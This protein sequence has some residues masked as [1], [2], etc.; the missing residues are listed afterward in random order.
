[1]LLASLA[2]VPAGARLALA[3]E[4]GADSITPLLPRV[5]V[6]FQGGTER[7]ILQT[8]AWVPL[9]QASDRVVYG[10]LRFSGDD[11][12]NREQNL[13]VGYRQMRGDVVYGG[14]VWADRRTTDR[15]STFYQTTLGAEAM[16]RNLEGRANVY[17]PLSKGKKYLTAPTGPAT[18]YLAGTGVYVNTAG[19]VI[20]E[21]QMG[22]DLEL[23]AR[24][25]FLENTVDSTRV[26]GGVY[27]FDSGKTENVSGWRTRLLLDVAPWLQVGGRYQHDGARG[28]QGFLEATFRFGGK[29]SFRSQGLRAR[30]DESAERD[31]DIV[32]S[33]AVVDSGIATPVVNA[34]TGT[35]QRILH[36]DNMA[37]PGGDGS[38]ERPFNTLAAAQAAIQ[39][40]DILYI[41]QGTQSTNGQNT[42]LTI[43][44]NG[45]SVIG[46]GSALVLDGA[47]LG[48]A[49]GLLPSSLVLIPAGAP[50]SITNTGGTGIAVN[51]D[52]ISIKGLIVDDPSGVGITATNRTGLTV[53]DVTVFSAGSQGLRADYTAPGD[54]SLNINRS[55]FHANNGSAI[56]VNNTAGTVSATIENNL[57]RQNTFS[58]VYTF[59]DGA[60]TRMT[61]TIRNNNSYANQRGFYSLTQNNA[62][63]TIAITGNSATTNTM[64]GYFFES[65]SSGT[66]V[67]V[68]ADQNI[69]SSNLDRGNLVWAKTGSRIDYTSSN[70]INNNN[71]SNGLWIE[72][73]GNNSFVSGNITDSEYNRNGSKNAQSGIVAISAG[74]NG[75][76]HIINIE[77]SNI[78]SNGGA[79]FSS[80]N[81]GTNTSVSVTLK[82]N[83]LN[84]NVSNGIS[85]SAGATAI[86]T[87]VLLDGNTTSLNAATGTLI[88]INGAGVSAPSVTVKNHLSERNASAG[89]GVSAVAGGSINT[90]HIDGLT[91]RNN[92]G[93]GFSVQADQVGGFIGTAQLDNIT[94]DSNGDRGG[95]IIASNSGNINNVSMRNYIATNNVSQ[96]L[97]V[98]IGNT[99]GNG[100][101]STSTFDRLN[102]SG[103]GQ[104]GL[105]FQGSNSGSLNASLTNST[106]TGN[107]LR[108]VFVDDDTTG[109][110]TVDMGGGAFNGGGRNRLFNNVGEDLRVDL[111]GGNLFARGNW[112]GQAGGPL[113][114]DFVLEG[115]ATLDSSNPLAADPGL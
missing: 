39:D 17:I 11:D 91:S 2:F 18:P 85:I 6:G 111:D 21:P 75:P 72:A 7:N 87:N 102:I 83:T 74:G 63:A 77:R 43:N 94:S 76:S 59:N 1:M 67:N 16:G 48:T 45:V 69:S 3:Q 97:A 96:G 53:E 36:L 8:R 47:K 64:E 99:T 70:G 33:S 104:N 27:H 28:S 56:F 62:N 26:Y 114:P 88:S 38:S 105:Y 23:G 89:F 12:N 66:R 4:T 46:S 110:F 40:N 79:G 55:V 19:V 42:G 92:T 98:F 54:Y 103:S 44:K 35:Q 58:G 81:G 100:S 115:G 109:T 14:H 80:S 10:D 57:I 5:D 51:G 49:N 22:I 86:S 113:G 95:L 50:P 106:I 107:T 90:V 78:S 108:G 71:G 15:G 34:A 112:W 61:A 52:N 37:A 13:G 93:Q 82:N 32:T 65:F 24:L 31:I 60:S 30:L 25:P 73:N 9:S 29:S 68:T 84:H 20:E 101:I 41:R